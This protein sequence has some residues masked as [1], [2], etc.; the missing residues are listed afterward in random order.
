M[1]KLLGTILL[2]AVCWGIAAYLGV[3][4]GRIMTSVEFHP[5][6]QPGTNHMV[7]WHD[8]NDINGPPPTPFKKL[9]IADDFIMGSETAV[10]NATFYGAPPKGWS[11]ACDG[12]KHFAP[13]SPNGETLDLTDCFTIRTNRF[14]AIVAAWRVKEIWDE[15]APPNSAG[16]PTHSS[17]QWQDCDE[18]QSVATPVV[19]NYETTRQWIPT[20]FATNAEFFEITNSPGETFVSWNDGNCANLYVESIKV[21]LHSRFRPIV[22]F[23]SNDWVVTFTDHTNNV[24]R[25]GRWPQ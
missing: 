3:I 4:H 14:E 5:A 25:T 15:P 20:N 2:L 10:S 12:G 1:K 8:I 9:T 11:I 17:I 13:K 22:R 23:T 16:L 18:P 19:T 7:V 24:L 21:R 6:D